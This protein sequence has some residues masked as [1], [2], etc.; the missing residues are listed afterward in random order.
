MS[1]DPQTSRSLPPNANLEQQ[2]KQARELLRAALA[3]D[4]EALRRV[5]DH[6]PRLRG[7]PLQELTG[8]PLALHDAQ[9]G[10]HSPNRRSGMWPD[11]AP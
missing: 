2:K 7:R 6:H 5:G 1:S 8:V 4:R 11:F 3:H 9:L 10:Y